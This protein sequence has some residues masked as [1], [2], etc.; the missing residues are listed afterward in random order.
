MSNL[1]L[2]QEK[3]DAL[4]S[5]Y[6]PRRPCAQLKYPRPK[7]KPEYQSLYPWI[8]L[9]ETDPHFV[10][11]AICECRLSAKRSDLG[12]HE[13]SIK[14]SENAQRKE[15][16]KGQLDTVAGAVKWELNDDDES[17]LPVL[18]FASAGSLCKVEEAD[19]GADG[20]NEADDDDDDDDEEAEDGAGNGAGEADADVEADGD[21]DDADLDAEYEPDCKRRVSETDSQ[22]SGMLDYLPLQVTINEFP[23][24]QLTPAGQLATQC[25][26]ATVPQPCRITIKKVTA[27]LNKS[28]GT[29]QSPAQTHEITSKATITPIASGCYSSSQRQ[30]QQ[31]S[32]YV[33]GGRQLQS[34]QL[35]HHHHLTSLESA[36][37]DSFDLFFDSICATVKG[38]PPKLATEGKIRV[39]QL[40]GELELRAINEREAPP[41]TSANP[42]DPGATAAAAGSVAGPG[43]GAGGAAAAAAAASVL[44]AAGS[45]QQIETVASTTK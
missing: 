23:H 9:D 20:E 43:T 41:S 31:L 36:P 24:A 38:L 25:Q 34:Y 28:A 5:E 37:R 8:I 15:V 16:S 33:A 30:Q 14:H 10:F 1:Q 2:T 21:T 4:R 11:C 42:A 27:P 12:K 17:L 39:M 32:S 35:Q 6:R 29:S 7:T 40:I 44:D 19:D 13:G 22:H 3:L 45:S 18:Q 26:P